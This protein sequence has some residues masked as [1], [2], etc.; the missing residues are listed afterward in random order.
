MMGQHDESVVVGQNQETG[1]R[2]S[3]RLLEAM[4]APPGRRW[5]RRRCGLKP[6]FSALLSN[7]TRRD[8]IT[9]MSQV[10]SAVS[11]SMRA[12]TTGL[13]CCAAVDIKYAPS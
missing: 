3:G 10:V 13:N 8:A 2:M 1:I 7:R 11:E 12:G 9:R 5:C 4:G 6:M